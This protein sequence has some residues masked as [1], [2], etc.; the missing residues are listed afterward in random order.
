MYCLKCHYS[1]SFSFF[2]KQQSGWLY[3]DYVKEFYREKRGI[4]E[5]Q[6]PASVDPPATTEALPAGLEPL[7]EYALKYL[8]D[9]YIEDVSDIYYV[10]NYTKFVNTLIPGKYSHIPDQDERVVFPL[11]NRHNQIVGYQG[12]TMGQS[13]IR[14]L[15]CKIVENAELCYGINRIDTRKPIFLVE[16]I[17]DALSIDNAIAGLNASPPI[18][19]VMRELG[20]GYSDLIVVL[21]NEKRN[22]E[23]VKQY[24]RIADKEQLGLFIWPKQ[25]SGYKD[26][27]DLRKDYTMEEIVEN[28]KR[29][30]YRKKLEKTVK[31]AIW[32]R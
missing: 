10:F 3:K 19:M 21:D 18:D 12:R 26:L 9:R 28:I 22:M 7:T 17:F 25:W 5:E 16:G 1:A 31:V 6:T 32:G 13:S 15:T 14:Y 30:T 24:R 29:H 20:V 8:K 27:N 2:L 23:I 11:R 4:C